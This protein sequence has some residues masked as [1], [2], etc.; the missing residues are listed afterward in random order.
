VAASAAAQQR[1]L[2]HRQ[3]ALAVSFAMHLDQRLAKIDIA[4]V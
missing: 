4:D 3:D 1:L 2:A